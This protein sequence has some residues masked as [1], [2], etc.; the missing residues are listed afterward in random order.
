MI[1]VH[2]HLNWIFGSDGKYGSA[3]RDTAEY[4]IDAELENAR[5]TLLAGFTTIQS[6]GA[7]S[8]VPLRDAIATPASSPGRAS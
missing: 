4:Q 8:D 3:N 7:A 2:V 5:K 1:D 6:P